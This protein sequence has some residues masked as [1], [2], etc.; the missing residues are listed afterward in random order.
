MNR[1]TLFCLCAVSWTLFTQEAFAWGS[2]SGPNGGAAYHR[3]AG[4]AY[5]PPS[6][7]VYTHPSGG[8]QPLITHRPGA[9]RP[10][11]AAAPPRITV[12]PI[13]P[14]IRVPRLR[15]V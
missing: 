3:A 2:V 9:P 13:A 7:G 12:A 10:I 15:R 1:L 11:M 5:R 14:P 6:G 4:T 8:A